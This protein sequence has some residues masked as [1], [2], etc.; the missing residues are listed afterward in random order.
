MADWITFLFL[1]GRKEVDRTGEDH[2]PRLDS[3]AEASPPNSN[4]THQMYTFL[5]VLVSGPEDRYADMTAASAGFLRDVHPDGRICILCDPS[6]DAHLKS[7][8]HPLRSLAD[9]ILV[10][11][12]PHEDAQSKNRY[13]KSRM[14]TFVDGDFLYLDADTLVVKPL[15]RIFRAPEPL[16]M[17]PNHNRPYPDNFLGP[18]VEYY[19][20]CE[21][22]LPGN[23]YYM[24]AGV[25][26][27]RDCPDAHVFAE[28]Y[29]KAVDEIHAKGLM[30]R[31]Q[32]AFNRALDAWG[33][34]F[35]V[36]PDRY[37][38]QVSTNPPTGIDA[39]VWHFYESVGPKDKMTH[40]DEAMQ[41]LDKG[42]FPDPEFIGRVRA[43]RVHL[44]TRSSEHEKRL[45]A[46]LKQKGS[47]DRREVLELTD[48]IPKPSCPN[49]FCTII[50]ANY[51]PYALN[52]LSSIRE[53]DREVHF[54]IFVSDCSWKDFRETPPEDAT[55]FHFPEEVTAEG[56]GASIMYKYR[57]TDRDAYRWSC[58]PVFINNLIREKGYEKV[59]YVDCDIFFFNAFGFLFDALE[60]H[61][62]LLTPHWRTPH[63]HSDQE[64]YRLLFNHGLYNAGFIAASDKAT[65][66]MDWWAENCLYSCAKASFP[67]EYVDQSI[68]NLMPVYFEGVHSLG[69][70]GC[71]VSVWNQNV[72]RRTL[73]Q[74]GSLLINE[75]YP[76][77]F[78][79][80]VSN[81]PREADPML[82][83]LFDRY[84]HSLRSFSE[85]AWARETANRAARYDNDYTE[86][87]GMDLADRGIVH[88][89]AVKG[90]NGKRNE[91]L[92]WRVKHRI[93]GT[94]LAVRSWNH[95]EN[96]AVLTQPQAYNHC[97]GLWLRETPGTILSS[98]PIADR[99]W[100]SEELE[101]EAGIQ[102][103]IH[104]RRRFPA[105]RLDIGALAKARL[106]D[107]VHVSWSSWGS[108]LS[109]ER[110][111]LNLP[112]GWMD[113]PGL[114]FE[115]ARHCRVIALLVHPCAY[116]SRKHFET[117]DATSESRL[118]EAESL[119][120]E[121]EALG[122]IT[123]D[124]PSEW[125]LWVVRWCMDAQALM[126]A[127][128][129]GLRIHIVLHEW[130]EW[131]TLRA[132]KRLCRSLSL[133]D[134]ENLE[135]TFTEYCTPRKG[136]KPL[137]ERLKSD[138]DWEVFL[139]D[140]GRETVDGVLEHFGVFF[141]S[142]SD[143]LPTTHLVPE[144]SVIKGGL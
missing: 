99:H 37:N 50:T 5:Y 3:V 104:L 120:G 68:L 90:V 97:L 121:D 100:T 123:G 60:T 57:E 108:L 52:L 74:D 130:L 70:K 24:N 55:F 36:L 18:E 67:G 95:R 142:A 21:W 92:Y 105:G 101:E 46:V 10:K 20:K 115:L 80:F 122:S 16:A 94:Y 53:Y 137:S 40:L 83:G 33:G 12:T 22:P 39:S 139:E 17:V 98:R 107:P 124:N 62:I 93:V 58:K 14:R 66:V 26:F 86:T 132:M 82:G 25:V 35:G 72:C 47:L 91:A 89:M 79:H 41:M 134:P 85:E 110:M 65:E 119:I 64:E 118:R 34:D 111:V 76:I 127:Q 13:L 48:S 61:R 81:V 71:N 2:L 143:I 44:A 32:P 129:R 113:T 7:V 6:T 29:M 69:H 42:G 4:E 87:N 51:L 30:I 54:N 128:R 77:V 140:T 56:I 135:C 38:A 1:S 28:V 126:E 31:D 59:V 49:T 144:P 43:S 112:L 133:P 106:V 45:I 11:D 88:R 131:D 9:H 117:R 136:M 84:L 102:W 63:P 78:V 125:L 109:M 114:A 116:A 15:D 8:G 141:Y 103:D 96:I 138:H 73:R 27:W 23:G 19:G 75:E